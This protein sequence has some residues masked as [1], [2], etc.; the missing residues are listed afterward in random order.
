MAS[1]PD[2]RFRLVEV[3]VDAEPLA[4]GYENLRYAT[5]FVPA[6][7]QSGALTLRSDQHR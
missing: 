4:C 6:R 2:R 3:S 7:G 5:V 1:T